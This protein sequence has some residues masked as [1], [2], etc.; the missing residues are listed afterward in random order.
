MKIK[1]LTKAR[2]LWNTGDTRLDRYNR[3]AWV[4]SIRRLGNKW[5]LAQ[6]MPRKNKAPTP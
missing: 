1:M 6:H 4:R 5:L 2:Q 3:I